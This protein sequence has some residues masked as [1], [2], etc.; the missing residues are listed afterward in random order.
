LTINRIATISD[1]SSIRRIKD[2]L[3]DIGG[4]QLLSVPQIGRFWASK[5]YYLAEE[6]IS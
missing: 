6:Y 4:T 3:F 2:I 1:H 5:I